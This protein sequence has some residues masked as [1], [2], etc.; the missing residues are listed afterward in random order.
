M[1]FHCVWVASVTAPAVN[2]LVD[3]RGRDLLRWRG[4]SADALLTLLVSIGCSNEKKQFN[5]RKIQNPLFDFS[6]FFHLLNCL[7]LFWGSSSL[8]AEPTGCCGVEPV[9]P[10]E[11]VCPNPSLLHSG[12]LTF[13][14]FSLCFSLFTLT[15]RANHRACFP[16]QF[17]QSCSVS[18][19]IS[20]SQSAVTSGAALCRC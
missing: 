14:F 6:W 1:A 12:K 15:N 8:K 19:L 2:L 18:L 16:Y 9:E 5:C 10:V 20:L 13:G 4:R 3:F 17:V 7:M 11:P